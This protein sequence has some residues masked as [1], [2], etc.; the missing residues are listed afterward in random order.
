MHINLF[1]V[2]NNLEDR[3]YYYTHFTDK[4]MEAE[5]VEELAQDGK[6]GGG[7]SWDLNEDG[8]LRA[9]ASYF[10]WPSIH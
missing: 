5:G 7:Q 9:H 2:C 4:E 8:Y 10:L 1:D 6:A 3:Y